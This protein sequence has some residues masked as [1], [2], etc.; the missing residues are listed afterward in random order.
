[1]NT[2][3]SHPGKPSTHHPLMIAA[4]IAI[5]LFCLA[6]TAAIMG[7]IPSS[8]GGSS[9]TGELTP[10]DR[11]ALASRLADSDTPAMAAQG[12]PAP[13]PSARVLISR[14][15]S[16]LPQLPHQLRLRSGVAA[17]S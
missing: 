3:I 4:A 14:T 9:T 13:L 10:S 17:A 8:L 12:A 2:P 16:T 7:W 11:A 1:M 5:I 6:G 15:D